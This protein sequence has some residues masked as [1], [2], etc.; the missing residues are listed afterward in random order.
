MKV[1]WAVLAIIALMVAFLPAAIAGQHI[2]GAYELSLGAPSSNPEAT[3]T[4][5]ACLVTA[6]SVTCNGME[7]MTM[8]EKADR[9]AN[10]MSSQT[11]D[12]HATRYAQPTRAVQW[13]SC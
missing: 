12:S 8:T 3:I 9:A 5:P 4:Q 13:R 6:L 7:T 2:V 11:G 10:G 1:F